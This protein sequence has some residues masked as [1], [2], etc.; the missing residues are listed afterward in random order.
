MDSLYEPVP[1]K[2]TKQ[3]SA[4]G[5]TG[6]FIS[7]FRDGE[8]AHNNPFMVSEALSWVDCFCIINLE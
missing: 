4:S 5:R 6:S 1:E 8:K 3:E 7:P 2:Q